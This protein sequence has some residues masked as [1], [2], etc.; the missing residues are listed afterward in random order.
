VLEFNVL[1]AF[2]HGNG[3]APLDA[4]PVMGR[5]V[6]VGTSESSGLLG[7]KYFFCWW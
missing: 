6:L 5:H 4:N 2:S 7:G 3:Y 1:S